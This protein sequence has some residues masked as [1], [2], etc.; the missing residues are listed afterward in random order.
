MIRNLNA[1]GLALA[2][3]FAAGVM[4]TSAASAQQGFLTSDGPVTLTG[5]ET[6]TNGNQIKKF[7]ITFQCPGSTF[8][9]HHASATPHEAITSGSFEM[10]ITP[11]YVN[12]IVVA[13]N[14]PVTFMMNGCDYVTRITETTGVAD[15]YGATI[16]LKC[17]A[18]QAV[19]LNMW[20]P[21][22]D[23]GTNPPMCVIHIGEEGN[24][25]QP[26]L[27]LTDTTQGGTFND[28]DL[29]GNVGGLHAIKTKSSE[30]P[31]LC[32]AAVTNSAEMTFDVTIKGDSAGGAA[33]GVGLSHG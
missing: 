21:G 6:G 26:G 29:T 2:A 1:M 12:C 4:L 17:P 24:Q 8:R 7:G 9:G 27:Q 31:I 13:L 22:K 32:P 23:N 20:T 10:T 15:T 28:I 25:N 3:V 5:T 14:W 19:A 33:T 11:N 18:G 16:S 30:D